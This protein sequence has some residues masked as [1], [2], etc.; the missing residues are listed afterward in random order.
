MRGMQAQGNHDSVDKGA[1]H[2]E[3]SSVIQEELTMRKNAA[4]GV[5]VGKNNPVNRV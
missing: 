3:P 5:V 1:G 4:R 2:V